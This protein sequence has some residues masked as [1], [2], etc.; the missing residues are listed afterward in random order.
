MV[1]RLI[2]QA[3]RG[4]NWTCTSAFA[5]LARQTILVMKP[6]AGLSF[7]FSLWLSK[8]MVWVERGPACQ[9]GSHVA[10][11]NFIT[12]RVGVYKCLSLIVGFAVTVAIWPR[13]VVSCRDF[14]LRA[15]ATFWVMSLV[16]IYT[17]KASGN[18]SGVNWGGRSGEYQF[19][20]W[21]CIKGFVCCLS[22]DHHLDR[23]DR[24][25]QVSSYGDIVDLLTRTIFTTTIVVSD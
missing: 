15:V 6:R 9:G 2:F 20:S 8:G 1:C 25:L 4:E 11:L 17:G 7:L 19:L 5:G 21:M 16:G 10:R 24:V 14:I 13:E 23:F 18:A 12:T 22:H 3:E